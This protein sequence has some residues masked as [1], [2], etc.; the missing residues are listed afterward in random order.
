[1]TY[2]C[3][4]ADDMPHTEWKCEVCG[5]D[6]SMWDVDCQYCP[7]PMLTKKGDSPCLGLNFSAKTTD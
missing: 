3:Q 7:P 4:D 6:N 1:M 2:R 5:T